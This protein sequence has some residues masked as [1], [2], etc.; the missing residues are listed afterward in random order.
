MDLEYLARWLADFIGLRAFLYNVFIAFVMVSGLFVV[1]FSIERYYGSPAS[2][3]LSR[4]FFQDLAYWFYVRTG[5]HS[6]FF[7]GTF[8]LWVPT[9]FPSLN[10]NLIG[11][12]PGW[13][14]YLIYFL[15]MEFVGYWFHRWVHHNRFLWAFHSV[16]HSQEQMTFA[17]QMRGHALGDFINVL[18]MFAPIMIIGAGPTDYRVIG[19]SRIFLEALQHA[20]IPW[21]FGPFY[22]ILIGPVFHG[23]HHSAARHQ[24][25]GNYGNL[26]GI[27]DWMFGTLVDEPERPRRYG[28]EG[29]S[30]P[31]FASQIFGP[32][33]M[34]YDDYFRRPERRPEATMPVS[35]PGRVPG[36]DT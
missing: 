4:N 11:G 36:V 13:Q 18:V 24:Y 17:T 28:V 6:L 3:Y 35:L 8:M 34:I 23:F 32:F 31:T 14:R 10:L 1:M 25:N 19:Y 20:D 26:L 2:R 33:R 29:L 15:L 5:L 12:L 16:H 9:A 7:S 22:R 30:M 21:R 27:W